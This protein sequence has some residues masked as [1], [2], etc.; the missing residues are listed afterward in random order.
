MFGLLKRRPYRIILTANFISLI[1]SGLNH[2][3]II[4]FVLQKTHSEEAVALLVTTITLP[5][6]FFLPFSGVLIDRLD[7]RY[8]TMTLDIV[9][10]LAVACVAALAFAGRVEVWHIYAMG[11][12]L[13]LGAFMFW[14]N[15]QALTQ[16]L[17][18]AKDV[19]PLNALVQGTAQSGWMLAGAVVGF[20]YKRIGLGG[21]LSMDAT[22]YAVSVLLMLRLRKGVHLVHSETTALSLGRFNRDFIAGLR[23]VASQRRVLILGT[24]AA[25]FTAAMMSQ[26]VLTAPF[27]EKVLKA[28][29]VGFGYCNAGWSLGAIFV[30][31]LAGTLF[32]HSSSHLWVLSGS[33]I[34]AGVACGVLPHYSLVAIGVAG[35]FV[36][37]SGRGMAG[38]GINSALMHEVPRQLMG[39]TQ[40]VIN[41]T[42][43]AMQLFLTM[44]AGWLC[45]RLS[46]TMGFYAVASFYFVAGLLAVVVARMP[47]S[48]ATLAPPPVVQEILMPEV[49]AAEL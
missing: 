42:G 45:E 41:F 40:N 4:W 13:G 23:Y 31:I 47:A 24:V 8:V 30:S 49:E 34:L 22:S 46:L 29:P 2:A 18:E 3:A 21:I 15:M 32:R 17:V 16:E 6:L 43:I 37:G 19:V 27:S 39:R 25:L 44:A 7:R 10:G 35:Y 26:N 14:P 20:L 28:G 38:V 5:S 12:V 11:V 48:G 1:G 33:L 9:R 36:M